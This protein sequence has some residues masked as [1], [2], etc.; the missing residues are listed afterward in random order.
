MINCKSTL[1]VDPYQL[2]IIE[3]LDIYI[4]NLS[5]H[6]CEHIHMENMENQAKQCIICLINTSNEGVNTCSGQLKAYQYLG[7]SKA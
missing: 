4:G 7:S 2:S 1:C 6:N 3:E 5:G